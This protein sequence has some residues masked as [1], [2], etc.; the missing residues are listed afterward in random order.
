MKYSNTRLE[1]DYLDK[2]NILKNKYHIYSET[3]ISQNF[4]QN[5][6]KINMISK[7]NI[8]VAAKNVPF[9]SK[10]ENECYLLHFI[11]NSWNMPHNPQLIKKASDN[12]D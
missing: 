7:Y 3:N 1:F 10:M 12:S 4:N 9:T 11:S 2:S 5:V 6:D 8:L